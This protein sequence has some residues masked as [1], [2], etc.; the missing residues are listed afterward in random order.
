VVDGPERRPLRRL[1]HLPLSRERTLM[2]HFGWSEERSACLVAWCCGSGRSP[3]RLRGQ[4]CEPG[5]AGD[6]AGALEQ[7]AEAVGP[8]RL[9]EARTGQGHGREHGHGGAG[10]VH[11]EAVLAGPPGPPATG[12]CGGGQAGE[13]RDCRQIVCNAGTGGRVS[14]SGVP[15]G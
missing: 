14:A 6:D 13:H 2:P 4:G 3:E 9:A 5:E 8:G 1:M 15:G 12:E 11:A 10:A 7:P